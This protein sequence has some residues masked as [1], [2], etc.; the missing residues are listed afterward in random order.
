MF[1]KCTFLI[2]LT[3]L[4]QLKSMQ[5][6]SFVVFTITIIIFLFKYKKDNFLNID[7]KSYVFTY[8]GYNK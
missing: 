3:W 1:N 4:Y 2:M 7:D 8:L 6:K 5:L